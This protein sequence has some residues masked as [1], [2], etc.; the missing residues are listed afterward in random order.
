MGVIQPITDCASVACCKQ[1]RFSIRTNSTKILTALRIRTYIFKYSRSN[2]TYTCMRLNVNARLLLPF[3]LHHDTQSRSCES[4]PPFPSSS[5]SCWRARR[6]VVPSGAANPLK[7]KES[8]RQPATSGAAAAAAATS[9][10]HRQ[11]TYAPAAAVN[12]LRVLTTGLRAPA[13][14][15]LGRR[16]RVYYPKVNI[17]CTNS[18]MA[19][20]L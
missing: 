3:K 9:S 1:Y 12:R 4:P 14:I 19:K 6:A 18:N 20:T 13:D 11:T 10:A 2:R 7:N 5:C 15:C 16:T 8:D 17:L